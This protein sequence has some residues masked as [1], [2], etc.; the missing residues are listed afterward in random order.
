MTQY[1]ILNVKLSNSQLNK[2]K[3]EIKNSTEV[4]V[5]LSSNVVGSNDEN[6]FSHNLLLPNAHFWS[7][8]KAFA[9]NSSAN[10]VFLGNRVFLGRPL[11][12]LLETGLPLIINALKPLA[13]GILIP[14]GLT[15]AASTTDAAIH[16]RTFVSGRP[17]EL[18]SRT[19]TLIFSNEE[20][21]VYHENRR[22]IISI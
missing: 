2:L 14:L 19:T 6:N 12:P 18:G 3:F 21:K 4:T 20:I 7:F 10:I 11:K 9:N 13:K 15:E 16:K 5:K 22:R 17:S 8:R 1:K